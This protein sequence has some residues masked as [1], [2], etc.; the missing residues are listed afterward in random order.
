M[1]GGISASDGGM[2]LEFHHSYNNI[3]DTNLHC[4]H[5]HDYGDDEIDDH[6]YAHCCTS[7]S[8]FWRDCGDCVN[9]FMKLKIVTI[10][11][12]CTIFKEG[13]HLLTFFPILKFPVMIVL[14][15]AFIWEFWCLLGN[16]DWSSTYNVTSTW[17]WMLLLKHVIVQWWWWHWWQ[18]R[19]W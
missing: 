11:T 15:I 18:W 16:T 8:L 6:D 4:H 2:K 13:K 9:N 5:N 1:S 3:F 19:W 12:H 10:T 7:P 14:T 17:L